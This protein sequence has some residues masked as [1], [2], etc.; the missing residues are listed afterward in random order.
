MVGDLV[1]HLLSLGGQ[2]LSGILLVPAHVPTPLRG[3]APIPAAQVS[4]YNFSLSKN[5]FQLQVSNRIQKTKLLVSDQQ[6]H[7]TTTTPNNNYT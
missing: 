3:A 6:L 4:H 1:G 7:P 5:F 2:G